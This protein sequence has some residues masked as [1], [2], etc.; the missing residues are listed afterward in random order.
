[1]LE[2]LDDLIDDL[3]DADADEAFEDAALEFADD[4][5]RGP[6]IA[7]RFTKRAMREGFENLDAGLELESHAFGYLLGTE[8]LMEGL[9][10]WMQDREPEFEGE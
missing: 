8:D 1:M 2:D 6:P 7:Q 4:V 5:A 9:T 10:A 3:E